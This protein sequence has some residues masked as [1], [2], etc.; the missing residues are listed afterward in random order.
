[1]RL[2]TVALSGMRLPLL[3]SLVVLVNH[4]PFVM[5]AACISAW[6]KE[7]IMEGK[8]TLFSFVAATDLVELENPLERSDWNDALFV[9]WQLETENVTKL[10]Q[11]L[12]LPE[13][14]VQI[15]N[16][17]I[18]EN[19]EKRPYLSMMVKRIRG[20]VGQPDTVRIDWIIYV[21][22]TPAEQPDEQP[23]TSLMVIDSLYDVRAT[24]PAGSTRASRRLTYRIEG[25]K[26]SLAVNK[27]YPAALRLFLDL[28]QTSD[29][30]FAPSFSRAFDKLYW[31]NMVY[32]KL[33]TNGSLSRAKVKV[34]NMDVSPEAPAAFTI[35]GKLPWSA[36]YSV[37]NPTH[38]TYV[39][40]TI[41]L[42]SEVW[43]NAQEESWLLLRQRNQI[44]KDRARAELSTVTRG[45]SEPK[46]L[47]TIVAADADAAPSYFINFKITD[48]EGLAAAIPLP[49]GFTLAP[50]KYREH[51]SS[52]YFLT[53]NVY[54]VAGLENGIRAEW[55]VFVKEENSEFPSFMMIQIASTIMS[56]TP[57]DFNMLEPFK[58]AASALEN[59]LDDNG[60]VVSDIRVSNRGEHYS[61]SASFLNPG[62]C[63]LTMYNYNV[64]DRAHLD[65]IAANDRIYYRNGIYD[66]GLWDASVGG[67]IFS[68]V[69][70]S[71]VSVS[72]STKWIEFIEPRPHEVLVFY[73]EGDLLLSPWNNAEEIETCDD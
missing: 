41:Q 57:V 43:V 60:M 61:F 18:L 23:A 48:L 1:M 17:A 19:E 51:G 44:Y 6:Q 25:N 49:E 30:S 2:F 9:H 8:K 16:V 32:S 35:T 10:E 72:D 4:V 46:V 58:P 38:I 69:D 31:P 67:M 34:A 63:K 5:S 40:D 29:D 68:V 52:D 21:T 24:T 55:K 39:P 3:L 50:I 28:S 14:N 73:Q 20:L 45:E 62:A 11:E 65:F 22:T 71:T 70:P 26:L 66:V 36:Y 12:G 27:K 59:R 13:K 53:L 7:E 42:G 37:S 47:F 15:A 64:C 56:P 33:F 54:G